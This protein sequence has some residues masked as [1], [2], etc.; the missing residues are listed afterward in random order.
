M[1]VYG[2]YVKF[3]SIRKQKSSQLLHTGPLNQEQCDHLISILNDLQLVHI[4]LCCNIK[5]QIECGK[6][7][8]DRE[9]PHLGSATQLQP[10]QCSSSCLHSL[11]FMCT[12]AV[13]WILDRPRRSCNSICAVTSVLFPRRRRYLVSRW[14]IS[15]TACFSLGV[16][17]TQ[18][19]HFDRRFSAPAAICFP[20]A[21]NCLHEA[22]M[23][24]RTA[25]TRWWRNDGVSLSRSVIK[26]DPLHVIALLKRHWWRVEG[27]EVV[28]SY[29]P[30]SLHVP[31]FPIL[32][33]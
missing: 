8:T 5:H 13:S 12:H 4:S 23:W 33:Q 30:L 15:A 9:V 18:A 31:F 1:S 19:K 24:T 27:V 11:V 3:P 16:S 22:L 2:Q 10:Q 17:E 29:E 6:T 7:H 28:K 25:L 20:F 26:P 32:R 14:K 21:E